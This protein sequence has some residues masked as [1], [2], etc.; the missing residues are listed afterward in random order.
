MV[1]AKGVE[2]VDRALKV[3]ECF[4]GRTRNHPC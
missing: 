4:D 2:A 3:L 1:E